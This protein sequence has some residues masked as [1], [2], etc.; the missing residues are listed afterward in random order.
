MIKMAQEDCKSKAA[1]QYDYES[2]EED[3]LQEGW[4]QWYCGLEGHEFMTEVD[5]DYIRDN[6]NLYGLRG[7]VPHFT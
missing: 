5:E 6:F 3:N 4:V 7:R 1:E 2:E